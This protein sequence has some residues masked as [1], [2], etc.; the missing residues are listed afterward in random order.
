MHSATVQ[1]HPDGRRVLL[2]P[3]YQGSGEIQLPSDDRAVAALR[4]LSEVLSGRTIDPTGASV[5]APLD[6]ARWQKLRSELPEAVALAPAV[7]WHRQRADGADKFAAEFHLNR[8]I[9]LAPNNRKLYALRGLVLAELGRDAESNADFARAGAA[10]A[11]DERL[12]RAELYA[13]LKKYSCAAD[14]FRASRPADL[15]DDRHKYEITSQWMK[16]ALC[17]LVAGNT[18]AYRELCEKLRDE[19][20]RQAARMTPKQQQESYFRWSLADI[21]TLA[22]GAF[23]DP[24]EL[25]ALAWDKKTPD[26]IIK[27]WGEGTYGR[28]LYRMGRFQEAVKHLEKTGDMLWDSWEAYFLAMAYAKSGDLCAASAALAMGDRLA[29]SETRHGRWEDRVHSELLRREAEAALA[30]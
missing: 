15:S 19:I 27:G 17:L 10:L 7:D 5:A 6:A 9:E 4:T 20:R 28:M 23:A 1:F 26:E 8:A 11:R 18:T 2:G 24:A 12:R 14:D 25:L 21:A 30:K 3:V 22:P 13:G 29:E 16:E